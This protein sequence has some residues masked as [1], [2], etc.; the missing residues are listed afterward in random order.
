MGGMTDGDT[1][2]KRIGRLLVR[3]VLC[4]LLL[5]GLSASVARAESGPNAGSPGAAWQMNM[6]PEDPGLE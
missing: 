6:L 4:A 1:V 3:G 5:L 2:M